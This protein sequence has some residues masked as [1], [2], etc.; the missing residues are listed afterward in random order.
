MMGAIH[1]AR[2][3]TIRASFVIFVA[4]GVTQAVFAANGYLRPGAVDP[5][6]LLCSPPQAGSAEQQCDLASVQRAFKNRSQEDIAHGYAELDFNLFSFTSSVGPI[7]QA[8]KLPKT[9][10]M[11]KR[12]LGDTK[13]ITDIGKNH[14]ERPRPYD[15]DPDLLDGEKEASFSYPSGHSTRAT[16][17]A[18]LLVELFPE[19]REAILAQGRQIGWDR[20][21]LGKHYPTDIYAGRVLAQAIVRELLADK[22]FQQDFAASKA[23]IEQAHLQPA[24][25]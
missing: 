4:C 23:E 21:V 6:T 15:I 5:V 16:V 22:K 24:L 20:V 19:D 3:P 2:T 9:E 13:A 12:A 10:A 11:F 18:L 1:L 17:Y 14:W 7:L 8:G 25:K